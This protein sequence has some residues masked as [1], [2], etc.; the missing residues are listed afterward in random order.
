MSRT[1]RIGIAF[2]A[3]VAFAVGVITLLSLLLGDHPELYSNS[4]ARRYSRVC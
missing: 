3:F 1:Q 4:R 2:S